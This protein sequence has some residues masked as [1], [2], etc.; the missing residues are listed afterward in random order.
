M[1]KRGRGL[2]SRFIPAGA[3]NTVVLR[4]FTSRLAVHPRWR[5]EHASVLACTKWENGSSPLARGTHLLAVLA[6]GDV[7]F[8]PAG[9]GN[10]SDSLGIPSVE[11]V[12]PRWRGEHHGP[13]AA[14]CDTV[15]SS[16][17]AR[18]TQ[19]YTSIANRMRRFIP[20]GA[21]NTIGMGPVHRARPVHPRWRGEHDISGCPADSGAGSS[22]LARGT[23]RT[24]SRSEPCG[25]FIPAGAG[26]TGYD[27]A[28]DPRF[29]VHPRWRG[30]HHAASHSSG[31]SCGSS[32]LAR[33]TPTLTRSANLIIRFIPAGAGNTL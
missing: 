22:P 20:A 1:I 4:G 32:P 26:N 15:G 23:R 8:I 11:A 19:A 12:H 3:G 25:R 16:P 28:C 2:F 5:G 31:T 9:A 29:S 17:L 13:V 10:T 14:R 18:G 30:E 33:G 24:L 27:K 21:G 6:H 7:R